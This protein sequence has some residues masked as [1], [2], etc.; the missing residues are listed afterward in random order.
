MFQGMSTRW[1][2][3]IMMIYYF[4]IKVVSYSCMINNIVLMKVYQV[5]VT[6][7]LGPAT[8]GL[9]FGSWHACLETYMYNSDLVPPLLF[10]QKRPTHTG[11]FMLDLFGIHSWRLYNH[12]FPFPGMPPFSAFSPIMMKMPQNPITTLSSTAP[13]PSLPWQTGPWLHHK[14]PEPPLL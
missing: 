2:L 1:N 10:Q 4:F 3:V 12:V 5:C 13:P 7:C 14:L 8:S 11:S 6:V 9:W